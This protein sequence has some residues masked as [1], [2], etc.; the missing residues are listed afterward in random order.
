MAPDE[1]QERVYRFGPIERRGIVGSFRLGQALALG[2]SCALA[3]D[4]PPR[5]AAVAGHARGL[6]H[7]CARHRSRPRPGERAH[8]RAMAAG[9]RRH[10]ASSGSAASI[11]TAPVRAS[12]GVEGSLDG[13]VERRPGSLPQRPQGLPTSE[14]AAHRRQRARRLPRSAARRVHRGRRA[15]GSRR[16]PAARRGARAPARAVGPAARRGR[17]PRL[18]DP[19][20][21]GHRAHGARRRRR[22]HPVLRRR[23]RRRRSRTTPSSPTASCWTRATRVIQEHE[24]LLAVQVDERRA[25]ARAARDR[26]RVGHPRRAGGP[27]PGRGAPRAAHA[28]A[29][30]ST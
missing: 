3:V 23:A 11:G 10:A 5:P 24:V 25:W 13:T 21:A 22:D 4:P 19:T 6:G 30:G 16:E 2:G 28:A 29:S 14:R 17:S 15:Q 20:T 12:T 8:G 7:G 9:A 1:R 18:G 27:G 26:R